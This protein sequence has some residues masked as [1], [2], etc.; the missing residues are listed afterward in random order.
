[1]AH[2]AEVLFDLS[3]A[4]AES[5]VAS[6]HIGELGQAVDAAWDLINPHNAMELALVIGRELPQQARPPFAEATRQLLQNRPDFE[7]EMASNSANHCL[8]R[9]FDND[10]EDL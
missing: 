3:R 8:Q 7:R 6:S 5:D 2:G 1:M 10:Y 4:L 9:V